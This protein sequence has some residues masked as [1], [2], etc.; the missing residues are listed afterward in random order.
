MSRIEVKYIF[1]SAPRL[2]KLHPIDSILHTPLPS[3]TP[4]PEL[5]RAF[6]SPL[7]LCPAGR[8]TSLWHVCV[9]TRPFLLGNGFVSMVNGRFIK[10]IE[11]IRLSALTVIR[12]G[13]LPYR[14][15][16]CSRITY[17]NGSNTI[18]NNKVCP[19]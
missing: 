5:Y 10:F 13:R 2:T 6:N 4:Q 11:S 12:H 17:A 3:N 9:G 19:C 8:V 18:Y 14:S 7:T 1:P 16:R 15:I